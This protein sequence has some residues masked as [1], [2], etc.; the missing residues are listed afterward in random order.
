MNLIRDRDR[1]RAADVLHEFGVSE[2]GQ[3][4]CRVQQ[5]TGYLGLRL[6]V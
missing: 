4:D 5:E 6:E 1:E 3:Y 2:D